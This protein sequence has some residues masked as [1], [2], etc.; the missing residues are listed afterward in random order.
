MSRLSLFFVL[1][2]YG[3]TIIFV[4][5]FLRKIIIYITTS[6]PFEITLQPAPKSRF[7]VV[8]RMAGELFLFSSLFKGSRSTWFGS[9][10]FHL[11]LVFIFIHHLHYFVEPLPDFLVRIGSFGDEAGMALIA[12]LLFLGIRRIGVDR[13]RYIT[14]FSDYFILVLIG[15]T[16]ITGLMIDF[17]FGA[18]VGGVEN[19]VTGL[20][21]FDPVN[22][23]SDTGFI[24]HLFLAMTFL[25]Y[26][27]FS[28]I[29]HAGGVFLSPTRYQRD[30]DFRETH[31]K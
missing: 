28:K 17:V 22:M 10:V 6:A 27:P 21:A 9:M 31:D 13:T 24:I 7:G 2:C 26:I 4:A 25:I 20:L 1:L 15:L 19:F 14:L 3:A 30:H 16:G 8:L 18:D 5:G 12:S 11:T 29:L 23:P